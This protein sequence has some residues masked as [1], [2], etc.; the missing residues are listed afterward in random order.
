[1]THSSL[2]DHHTLPG[3]ATGNLFTFGLSFPYDEEH[4]PVM[5]G[6]GYLSA[7]AEDMAHYLIPFFNQ[8]QYRDQNVLQAQGTGWYDSSWNWH[9]G[10]SGDSYDAFSGGHNSISTHM[11]LWHM[12]KLGVIVLMNTRLENPIQGV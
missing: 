1:M 9:S 2:A 6:V 5:S 12:R 11:Q 10:A 8:G 4:V 7:S 3:A